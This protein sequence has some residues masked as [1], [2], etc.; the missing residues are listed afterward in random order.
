M[1][2][3]DVIFI[4]VI[5]CIPQSCLNALFISIGDAEHVTPMFELAQSMKNH[6]VTFLTLQSA[7]VYINLNLYSSPSFRI[8]YANDSPNAFFDE[9]NH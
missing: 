1:R 4:L 8:I 2:L 3:N 5:A 7:Q 9:K 6:N